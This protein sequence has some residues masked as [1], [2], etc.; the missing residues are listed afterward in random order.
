MSGP[1]GN[2]YDKY[3]TSNPVARLLVTRFLDALDAMVARADPEDLLD[4]GCG[5]GIV[6]ARMAGRAGARRA[7]GVDRENARLRACWSEHAR[8]GLSFAV[9]DGHALPYEDCSFDL[10][11]AIEMLMQSPDPRRV[12]A[13][14]ARVARRHVLV[15]V[16]REPLWRMLNV[17]RGAYLRSW[18]NSPGSVQHFSSAGLQ[19]LCGAFGE[20][21]ATSRPLPW[22]IVLVRVG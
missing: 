20:P 8:D 9:G 3:A 1:A 15:S 21:L 17:A 10:V 6:T 22:T 19:T 5:E 18:G 13:E 16:P 14:L 12:L 2:T 7:V 11:C 4:V